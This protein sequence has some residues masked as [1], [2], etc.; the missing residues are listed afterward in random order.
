LERQI[1]KKRHQ[2]MAQRCGT[3]GKQCSLFGMLDANFYN[4][5][6]VAPE[7]KAHLFFVL[8]KPL[9]TQ[10]QQQQQQRFQHVFFRTSILKTEHGK[11]D[12]ALRGI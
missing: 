12:D 3:R 2:I 4:L 8:T 1:P 9:T 10:A 6:R 11:G 5:L 7:E